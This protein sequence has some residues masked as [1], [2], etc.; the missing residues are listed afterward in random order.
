MSRGGTWG[1]RREVSLF[2]GSGVSPRA[3][4][5]KAFS[6]YLVA[7]RDC[8]G[9]GRLLEVCPER[10]LRDWQPF[11][12]SWSSHHDFPCHMNPLLDAMLLQA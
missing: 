3:D 11:F 4:K 12:P 6:P 2:F 5:L 8:V 7:L 9:V 1:I 10:Q